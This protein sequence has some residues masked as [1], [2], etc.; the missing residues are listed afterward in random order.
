MAHIVKHGAEAERLEHDGISSEAIDVRSLVPLDTSTLL[1]SVAKTG[2]FFTVEENPRLCG[3]GAELVSIVAEEAFWNLDGPSIR[4]TTPHIPL[5][6]AASL[7]DLALPSA[8]RIYEKVAKS[9]E[10][11]SGA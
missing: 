7:E 10:P 5:P 8:D 3:W 6:P 9:V 4:I 1:E 2:R 11:G